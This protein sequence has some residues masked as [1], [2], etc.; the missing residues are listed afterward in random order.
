MRAQNLPL[1]VWFT[2]KVISLSKE[3]K[4]FFCFFFILENDLGMDEDVWM[5]PLFY[6][7]LSF[8]VFLLTVSLLKLLSCLC[9]GSGSTDTPSV[10]DK[11]ILMN[12][13]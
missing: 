11:K 4:I 1:K 2:L 10:P 9:C 7:L 12:F 3:I 6:G 8:V 5:N 13:N